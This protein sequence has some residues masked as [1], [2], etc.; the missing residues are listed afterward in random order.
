MWPIRRQRRRSLAYPA[1]LSLGAG[2]LA[3]CAVEEPQPA[4]QTSA[5]RPLTP[6]PE[7]STAHDLAPRPARKPPPPLPG[8]TPAPAQGGEA[9]ATTGSNSTEA[10]AGPEPSSSASDLAAISTSP[11]GRAP[12]QAE[13]IGLDQPS[14]TRLFGP[15]TEKLDEPPATVWRY[16]TASCELDLFF[17]LDLRSGNMRTLHYS[18]KGEGAEVARRQECW[19][20]LIAARG[21]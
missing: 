12:S 21:G 5:V 20:S 1:L 15:A 11:P 7:A 4:P 13:L 14:A 6:R 2:V 16:K 19:R 10:A 17:Y 3:S 18:F 8:G 9:L